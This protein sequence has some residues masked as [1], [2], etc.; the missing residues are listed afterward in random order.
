[1]IAFYHKVFYH[2]YKLAIITGERSAP[3][4]SVMPTLAFL[5]FCNLM[6]IKLLLEIIGLTPFSFMDDGPNSI[7]Y[8]IG[9]LLSAL[10][11]NYLYFTSE[12]RYKELIKVYANK[13]LTKRKRGAIITLIYSLVSIALVFVL[14]LLP[15]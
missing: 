10:V 2:L 12:G 9:L 1:M 4:T 3:L 7:Y 5:Q 15:E 8:V 14:A 11:A 6:C 13:S